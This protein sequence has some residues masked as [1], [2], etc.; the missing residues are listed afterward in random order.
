MSTYTAKAPTTAATFLAGIDTTKDTLPCSADFA[1][2]PIGTTVPFSDV[3]EAIEQVLKKC[4][5]E[6]KIHEQ[7]TIMHGEMS[8]IMHA[9][10]TCHQ[11]LLAMGCPQVISK[12]G[13]P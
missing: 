5:I 7:G 1:V 12:Y 6:Y 2:Y 4:H 13:T 9:I 3:I 10:K 8:V 11:A